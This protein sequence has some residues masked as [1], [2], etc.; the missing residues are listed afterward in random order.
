MIPK[1]IHYCWFGGN[2]LPNDVKKCI[3][4]WKKYCPEYKIVKWDEKSFDVKSHPFCKKAYEEKKWAFVSDYARLKIIYDN[5]GIYLDTDVE[6]LKKPDFLLEHKFYAA[7]QQ[8]EGLCNTGLGFGAEKKNETV[9]KMLDIYDE[10]EFK[11]DI[12]GQIQCP[13]LNS[14]VL[15]EYGFSEN[16]TTKVQTVGDRSFV[17]PPKYFDPLAPGTSESLVCNDTVSIH[18]YSA[19]WTGGK[20]RLKRRIIRFIGQD[21]VMKLKRLLKR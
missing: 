6:L 12:L 15:N 11:A 4:S 13:R 21:K 7:S 5:G 10:V 16:N 8:L 18:H 3:A 2:P 1:V 14:K 17:Y 9:K 20:Q 19:S